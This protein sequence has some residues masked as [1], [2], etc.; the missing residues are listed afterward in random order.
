MPCIGVTPIFVGAKHLYC[1]TFKRE[2][3]P[4]YSLYLL[5]CIFCTVVAFCYSGGL[6]WRHHTVHLQSDPSLELT[7][8]PSLWPVAVVL[9]GHPVYVLDLCYPCV[10]VPENSKNKCFPWYVRPSTVLKANASQFLTHFH[11]DWHC[12]VNC[13]VTNH[14]LPLFLFLLVHGSPRWMLP[15]SGSTLPAT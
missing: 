9:G 12:K 14:V 4:W 6:C 11:F 15:C 7:S 8:P 2:P 13:S 10:P 5:A 3:L 1:N